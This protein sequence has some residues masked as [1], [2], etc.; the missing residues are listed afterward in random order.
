MDFFEV[1]KKRQSIREFQERPVEEEKIQQILEAARLAPSAGNLQAYEIYLVKNR[2]KII[3]LTEIL[4]QDKNH[5]L[6]PVILVFACNPS[7]TVWKYGERGETLYALQDTTIAAAHTQL[8]A[9]ALG[10]ASVWIGA[11]DEDAIRKVLGIPQELRP[12]IIMPIGYP[13]EEREPHKHR[14]LKDLVHQI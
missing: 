10:L 13:A 1:I 3:A 14:S 2:E 9:T 6:A 5:K 11:F 7:R 4:E 12:I 8:A